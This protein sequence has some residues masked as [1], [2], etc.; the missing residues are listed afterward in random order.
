MS[1]WGATFS[2]TFEGP[3][4]APGR[5]P[6]D[7]PVCGTHTDAEILASCGTPQ[8]EFVRMPDSMMILHNY[9]VQCTRCSSGLLL[10]WPSGGGHGAGMVK[11]YTTATKFL[12]PP[13]SSD[14]E[15]AVTAPEV[16]PAAVAAD[17]QQAELAF[18]AGAEYG[19]ALLLRRAC[20]NICRERG[21]PEPPGEGLKGQLLEMAKRGIITQT[22]SDMADSIRIIG[23]EIAHPD[24]K[25]PS[26]ITIEDVAMAREF[27]LQLIRAIYVDPHRVQKLKGDLGKKGVK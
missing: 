20:Q 24:P 3:P 9:L 16:V 15:K 12:Y 25:T 4:K 27:M 22:L 2:Q 19:A 7:C 8:G 1:R 17:I 18:Y 6:L 26:V 23:N 11:S 14:L 10:L 13:R 21:I 5:V